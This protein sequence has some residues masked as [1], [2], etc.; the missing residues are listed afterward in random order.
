MS[1]SDV[2]R[3]VGGEEEI[4]PKWGENLI[5]VKNDGQRGKKVA[6]SCPAGPGCARAA[7]L[8]RSLRSFSRHV[9]P[10]LTS[11]LTFPPLP[12]DE[13]GPGAEPRQ[14]DRCSAQ[15]CRRADAPQCRVPASPRRRGRAPCPQIPACGMGRQGFPRENP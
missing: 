4:L 14:R 13:I 7:G 8:Q 10:E 6:A 9:P 3:V 1:G 2:K 5:A 11:T 12:G 15:S